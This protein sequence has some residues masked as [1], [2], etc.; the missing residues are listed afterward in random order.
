MSIFE[1]VANLSKLVIHHSHFHT[2][3]RS[4][5]TLLMQISTPVIKPFTLQYKYDTDEIM[6]KVRHLHCIVSTIT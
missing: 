3:D 4:T 1:T 5:I 6:E 2:L